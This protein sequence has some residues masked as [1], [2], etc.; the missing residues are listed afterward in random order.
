METREEGNTLSDALGLGA[1]ICAL[2]VWIGGAPLAAGRR[3]WPNPSSTRKKGT[4]L[5]LLLGFAVDARRETRWVAA[6]IARRAMW[7]NHLWQ[8]LAL[9]TAPGS[10]K[11]GTAVLPELHA[12]NMADMKWKKYFTGGCANWRVSRLQPAPS[13]ECCDFDRCFGA[14]D[15]RAFWRAPGFEAERRDATA[16]LSV[17]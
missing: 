17:S 3:G 5:S 12:G 14:E 11:C 1:R 10:M 6:M 15:G 9:L 16:V 4:G 8:D 13:L 7:P 2:T